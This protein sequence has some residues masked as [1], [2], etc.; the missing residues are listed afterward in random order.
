MEQSKRV[1]PRRAARLH[2]LW[3]CNGS[4]KE[5]SLCTAAHCALYPYRLGRKP[6]AEATASLAGVWTHPVEVPEAHFEKGPRILRA[7]RRRCIDCSGGTAVGAG[8]C[9]TVGCDLHPFRKGKGNRVM[10]EAQRVAA[11]EHLARVNPRHAFPAQDHRSSDVSEP[12]PHVV[13]G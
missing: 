4:S 5:V 8:A 10:S 1:S 7:I 2:C 11:A 3:C 9:T 6:S 13:A 12:V